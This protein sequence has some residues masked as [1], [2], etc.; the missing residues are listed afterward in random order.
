MVIG[1]GDYEPIKGYLELTGYQGSIYA[2]PSRSVY[3]ALDVTIESLAR[4]PAGEQ[5]K[6]YMQLGFFTNLVKS[7]WVCDISLNTSLLLSG[8][9]SVVNIWIMCRMAR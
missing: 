3:R 8:M 9:H 7:T 2:D 6:S 4:P 1:C 5:K